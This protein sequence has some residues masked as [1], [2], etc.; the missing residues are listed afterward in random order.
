MAGLRKPLLY[1]P[2]NR[3]L[4]PYGGF[5]RRDAAKRTGSMSNWR[6]AMVYG[7]MTRDMERVDIINRSI[8]LINDDP[9]A[10]GI[11]ENF[12]TTVIGPGLQPLPDLNSDLLG[13]TREES[14]RISAQQKAL[15]KIWA[16]Y[17]DSRQILTDGEIQHL[18]ARCLYGMGE[19]LE[20]MYMVK[21]QPGSFSQCG[22][23]INPLRLK[24]PTDKNSDGNI[25]SG[26]RLG[27]HGEP[28]S[29]FIKKADGSL[30]D[31]SLNFMEIPARRGNRW[32][33]LHDYIAKDP[34]QV[35]GYPIL[36]PTIRF[37]RDFA[38][39][40]GAELTSNVTTAAMAVF[41]ALDKDQ[42]PGDMANSLL[43][44][45]S[46][47]ETDDRWESIAPGEIRY[48]TAGQKPEMLSA[49]R[50]GTTFDPFTKIIKKAI[51]MAT[52]IPFAV[53]FKDVDGVSFAGFRAAMLEAWRV[54]SYHRKR[55]GD[56]DCQRKYTMLMEEAWLRGLLDI[57]DDFLLK[58]DAYTTA[59][60]YGAPKGDIEPYKA[61]MADVLK[62]KNNVKSMERIIIEDGGAGFMEETDQISDER[63][64]LADKGLPVTATEG[65]DTDADSQD[66]E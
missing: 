8:N 55:I 32:R 45:E 57:G 30:S 47:R 64:Q 50:P 52:G 44:P 18:K 21:T 65:S 43:D 51:S 34:E 60:W 19:S 62:N 15:Y 54:Y 11:I 46:E 53:A 28:I 58:R 5:I 38:D 10:A 61:I 35:R 33:I 59:R 20:I 48:G 2:D 6:P 1:G 25:K 49:D 3:P 23:V 9:N 27:K 22:Q 24:T 31:N 12:A 4:K 26:I 16:P 17:A 13:I 37:F 7:D 14:R 41:V 40:L 29:Y 39:L 56:R 63:T 42:D 36:S 66:D